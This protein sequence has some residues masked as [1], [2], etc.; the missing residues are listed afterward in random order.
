MPLSVRARQRVGDR[1]PLLVLTMLNERN[2]LDLMY[3]KPCRER[4]WPRRS[5]IRGNGR[6]S[7]RQR[8]SR[9]DPWAV[10]RGTRVAR[11]HAVNR[12]VRSP[13]NCGTARGRR[14]RCHPDTGC[15]GRRAESSRCTR[16]PTCPGK[17]CKAILPPC[18]RVRRIRRCHPKDDLAHHM[19]SVDFRTITSGYRRGSRQNLVARR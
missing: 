8:A 7:R 3:I 6:I 10:C 4:A 11:G 18:K 12:P 16:R 5:R 1:Q 2:W 17:V 13:G 15:R 9:G 19:C 14:R